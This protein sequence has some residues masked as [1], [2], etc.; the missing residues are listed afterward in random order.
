MTAMSIIETINRRTSCRTYSDRPIEPDHIEALKIYLKDTTASPFGSEIRFEL[1]DFRE[2]K[3]NGAAI[4]GTY[5]VIKGA[6]HFIAGAVHH[7]RKS[8]EDFGYCMENN[9]LMAT[10]LGLGTCWLGGTFNRSEFAEKMNLAGA[11]LL[12][13]VSPVGYPGDRRSLIDRV[14]RF[15]AGSNRRR[16]WDELFFDGNIESPLSKDSAGSYETPLGMIHVDEDLCDRLLKYEEIQDDTHAHTA[17]HA[18]EIQLPF[19]QSVLKL[20]FHSNSPSILPPLTNIKV[21][22][23]V[24]ADPGIVLE[25]NDVGKYENAKTHHDGTGVTGDLGQPRVSTRMGGQVRVLVAR[26]QEYSFPRASSYTNPIPRCSG[27]RPSSPSSR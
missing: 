26:H 6:R 7:G 19:L 20:A 2:I 3:M 21:G 24:K 1:L 23:A 13:A 15:S 12:P 11:E 8:M 5:G 10:S 9:I 27:R 4:P 25:L 17:E 22:E 16:S 14:F 18:L